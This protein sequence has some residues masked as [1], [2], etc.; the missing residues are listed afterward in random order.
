[1]KYT[2]P[3]GMPRSEVTVTNPFTHKGRVYEIGDKLLIRFALNEYVLDRV[4][5]RADGWTTLP[6]QLVNSNTSKEFDSAVAQTLDIEH[7]SFMKKMRGNLI[8]F[9]V[10]IATILM[11]SIAALINEW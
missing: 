5:D 7:K 9:W 6:L 8:M 2:A 10:F 11:L 3:Q 1:M 4:N